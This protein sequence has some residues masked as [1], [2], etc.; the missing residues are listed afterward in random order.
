MIHPLV[1]QPLPEQLNLAAWQD[2]RGNAQIAMATC[3]K[4]RLAWALRDNSTTALC[5]LTAF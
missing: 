2:Y 3:R 5:C 1:K 4:A